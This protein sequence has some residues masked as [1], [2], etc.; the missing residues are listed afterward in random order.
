M[1]A[2]RQEW[3][4]QVNYQNCPEEQKPYMPDV[5]FIVGGYGADDETSKVY[6]IF[7]KDLT[8]EEQFLW[9]TRSGACFGGQSDFV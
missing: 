2:V 3:E 6:K 4:K 5:Q 1:A 9:Q 8:I 7:V